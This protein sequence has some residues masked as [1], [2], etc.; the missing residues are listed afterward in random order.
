VQ[1]PYFEKKI[2]SH[3]DASRQHFGPRPNW[4]PTDLYTSREH[5]NS[6]KFCQHSELTHYLVEVLSQHQT[7]L[8][9]FRCWTLGPNTNST[10]AEHCCA[11]LDLSVPCRIGTGCFRH[12]KEYTFERQTD[13]AGTPTRAGGSPEVHR[14]LVPAGR[15]GVVAAGTQS[16][17]SA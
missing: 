8:N 14:G 6:R 16:L 3:D 17:S 10:W 5:T 2:H 12:R 4:S 15:D 11:R 13:L 1:D 9:R 7:S